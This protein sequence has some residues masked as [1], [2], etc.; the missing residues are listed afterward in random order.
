[1]ACHGLPPHCPPVLS[2]GVLP[3]LSAP[4]G[5]TAVPQY[6]MLL[7]CHVCLLCSCPPLPLCLP[8][9][10]SSFRSELSDHSS[11][12]PAYVK[13]PVMFTGVIWHLFVCCL[14]EFLILPWGHSSCFYL[15]LRK[16]LTHCQHLV[17]ASSMSL[18]TWRKAQSREFG[19]L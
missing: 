10:W 19:S 1:M 13:L 9:S 2:G 5:L 15:V 4:A 18:N 7:P 14:D 16:Y 3:W 11:W 6:P 12:L 8:T 17:G